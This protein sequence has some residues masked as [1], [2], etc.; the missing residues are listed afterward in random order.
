MLV[1]AAGFS[2]LHPEQASPPW[3]ADDRHNR[4]SVQVLL[5]F[6]DEILIER[7]HRVGLVVDQS[8][9]LSNAFTAGVVFGIEVTWQDVITFSGLKSDRALLTQQVD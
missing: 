1:I 5:G 8:S 4:P 9:P 7:S 2:V 3:L 6:T